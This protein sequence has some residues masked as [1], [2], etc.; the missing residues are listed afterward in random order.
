MDQQHADLV[1]KRKGRSMSSMSEYSGKIVLVIGLFGWIGCGVL[2]RASAP[3][4]ESQFPGG[5]AG[6]AQALAADDRRDAALTYLQLAYDTK[7]RLLLSWAGSSPQGVN[8]YE[9]NIGLA[10]AFGK[11]KT[12]EA[13]PFLIR[14]IGIRRLRNV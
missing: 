9:F 7:V 6:L 1:G 5:D 12:K 8:P 10:I 4:Q 3:L 13:I 2:G 14:H 11:F